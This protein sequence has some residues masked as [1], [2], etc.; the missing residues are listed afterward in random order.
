MLGNNIDNLAIEAL[1]KLYVNRQDSGVGGLT[2]I[3][4]LFFIDNRHRFNWLLEI[5]EDEIS[6]D[7]LCWF[8]Q[9]RLLAPLAGGKEKAKALLDPFLTSFESERLLQQASHHSA[10]KL[11][12]SMDVDIIETFCLEGYSLPHVCLAEEGDTV[13]DCGAFNGN[14]SLFFAS[15]VGKSGKVYAFEPIPN[16]YLNLQENLSNFP[17]LQERIHIK[18]LGVSSQKGV[19]R[20]RRSGAASR[21]D[22][23]GDIEV[24][25]VT[26]DDFVESHQLRHISL[27][28]MDIE[29]YEKQAISGAIKTIKRFRPKIMICVYHLAEDMVAIPEMILRITPWYKLYL[30]HHAS[31][32]GELVLYGVP[33]RHHAIE[34]NPVREDI[35][36]QYLPCEN[37]SESPDNIVETFHTT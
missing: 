16:I 6:R 25:V 14:S 4:P 17:D 11:I 24:E 30:R 20:F 32:D 9:F 22:P 31:H 37:L 8:I 36:T 2:N 28:K 12:D 19:L 27:I 7:M 5:L 35:L 29:G 10:K 26:I 18:N 33:K 3:F 21:I 34:T 15:C 13:I 23:N 1:R